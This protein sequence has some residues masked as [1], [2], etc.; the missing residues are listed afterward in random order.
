MMTGAFAGW[1]RY[2]RVFL[3][4]VTAAAVAKIV[5]ADTTARRVCYA[6]VAHEALLARYYKQPCASR[7]VPPVSPPVLSYGT[8]ST[9][10][11]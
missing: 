4:V 9:M 1:T 7:G 11:P 6:A 2:W 5:G 8:M 3:A 10:M